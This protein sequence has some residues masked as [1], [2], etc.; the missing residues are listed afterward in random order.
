MHLKRLF[1][2][3]REAGRMSTISAGAAAPLFALGGM[4]GQNYSLSDALKKGP[5]LA[6]FYKIS[7]PVCQFTFPFLERIYEAYGDSNIT[8]WGISQ[9]D[10]SGTGEFMNEFGV[11]FPSLIDASG[12]KTSKQYGLTNVPSIF[13]IQPDGKVQ[14]ATVGFNKRDLETISTDLSKVSGKPA[15]PVFLPGEKVPDYRPG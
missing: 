10:V 13:L 5:V 9:D 8:F 2:W 1:R 15:H 6:A 3:I 7:C 12:Y 11:K 14:T 4:N